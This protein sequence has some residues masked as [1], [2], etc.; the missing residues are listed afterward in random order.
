MKSIIHRI[1]PDGCID[2]VFDLIEH[3]AFI[4]GIAETT[5]NLIL[6]GSVKYIGIRFLPQTISYIFKSDTPSSLNVRLT[7]DNI[8]K[9]LTK[10]SAI[11]LENN[12]L[13]ECLNII[14]YYLISF[15]KEYKINE[16]FNP[17]IQN[18]CDFDEMK[19]KLYKLKKEITNGK[20]N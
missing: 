12:N 10:M 2:I 1:L 3:R 11:V 6:S 18:E 20:E 8:S 7:L 13:S 17:H 4:C 15:F 9:K 19:Q 14:E 5:E 16:K